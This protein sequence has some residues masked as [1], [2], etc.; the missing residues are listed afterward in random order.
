MKGKLGLVVGLGIGYVLGARDGRQRYDKI[1]AQAQQLWGSPQVRQK[2][3][4]A[5]GLA[6]KAVDEATT[7]GEELVRKHTRSTPEQPDEQ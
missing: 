6:A 2:V 3:E 4:A 7:A 1:K 5:G